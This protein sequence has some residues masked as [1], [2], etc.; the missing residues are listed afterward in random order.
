MA[1]PAV[2]KNP[3]GITPFSQKASAEPPVEWDKWNQQLFLGIDAKDGVNM[4]KLL[5]I[6]PAIRKPQDSGYE[7]PIE[8]ETDKQIRERNLRNQEKRVA[9]EN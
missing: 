6:P 4:T 2:P 5:Q 8:G 1:Q 3:L 9:W 7:L